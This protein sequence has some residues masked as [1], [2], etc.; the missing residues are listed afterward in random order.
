M[1]GDF[2]H[3]NTDSL[4]G[5]LNK[6]KWFQ[7]W[8]SNM[9]VQWLHFWI[10]FSIKDQWLMYC[11]NYNYTTTSC[12]FRMRSDGLLI[13]LTF[14]SVNKWSET[15]ERFQIWFFS[16]IFWTVAIIRNLNRQCRQLYHILHITRCYL[17]LTGT[18]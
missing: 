9:V 13:A 1:Q 7:Q 10:Q 14:N 4:S 12:R 3:K 11:Q 5:F 2:R 8:N 15:T 16:F 6:I 17:P 18:I